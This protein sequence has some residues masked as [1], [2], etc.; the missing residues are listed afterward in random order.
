MDQKKHYRCGETNGRDT[1]DIDVLSEQFGA[2]DIISNFYEENIAVSKSP[3]FGHKYTIKNKEKGIHFDI[4]VVTNKKPVEKHPDVISLTDNV[5]D[6]RI[7]DDRNKIISPYGNEIYVASIPNLLTMKMD[8]KTK[9]GKPRPK[10]ITDIYWLIGMAN[11]EGIDLEEY[12]NKSYD[13][14]RS[15][16]FK[17]YEK[18]FKKRTKV[19]RKNNYI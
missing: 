4:Y 10:D 2:K 18:K 11:D 1:D 17:D 16:K 14:D 9:N 12:Y 19:K 8:V 13:L 6:L 3:I 7:F 5:L 15:D